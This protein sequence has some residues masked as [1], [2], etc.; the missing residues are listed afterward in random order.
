M[1]KRIGIVGGGISG[2]VTAIFLAR[3][4]HKVSIFEK[5]LRN[6]GLKPIGIIIEGRGVNLLKEDKSVDFIK[7]GWDSFD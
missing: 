2:L 7:T 6:K 1:I 5:S 4:G 3:E